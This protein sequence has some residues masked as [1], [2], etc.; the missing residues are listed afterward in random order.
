MRQSIWILVLIIQSIYAYPQSVLTGVVLDAE[1]NSLVPYVSIGIAG[2]PI[3]TVSNGKGVFSIILDN[4]INNNDTLKFSSIGYRSEAFLIGELKDRSKEKPLSISLKKSINQLKQVSI[5]SKKANVK[6]VGYETNSKLFG[7][8]F[9]SGEVGSQAGVI[10]AVKHPGTNIENVSFF[11]IQNSFGHLVFRMN[12]YELVND[13]PGDNILSEN[14]FIK[15]DNKQTGKMTFDLSK[16]NIYLNKSAL[17]TLE[18]IEAEPATKGN[19][20]IAAV[21]FGHTYFRQASQYA[22]IKKGT[23]LGLSVKTNY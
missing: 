23:G 16:Y 20:A 21:V 18:W 1:D 11:I 9:G 12:L 13:K 3:G 19:L 17:M 14:I 22:W 6:I 10:V 2:K 15:V 8:G 4:K 5:V 7:L